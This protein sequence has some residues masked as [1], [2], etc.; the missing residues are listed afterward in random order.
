MGIIKRLGLDFS[1]LKRL[2][3][4]KKAK[5]GIYGPPNAGKTSLATTTHCQ[6]LSHR[7]FCWYWSCHLIPPGLGRERLSAFRMAIASPCCMTAVVKGSGSTGWTVPKGARISGIAPRNSLPPWYS[8]ETW[9]SNRSRQ[10]AMAGR[11][12]WFASVTNASA[13]N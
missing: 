1:W 6:Q 10:T 5:I 3:K 13:R 2:F 11:S 9:K 12:Q 8:R 7:S 4:K